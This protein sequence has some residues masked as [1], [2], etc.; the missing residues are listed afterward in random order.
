MELLFS[1]L[2]RLG[3]ITKLM[4]AARKSVYIIRQLP[5]SLVFRQ[6]K[7]ARR[8]LVFPS[9]GLMSTRYLSSGG[10]LAGQE[11]LSCHVVF[12]MGSV[13]TWQGER[14]LALMLT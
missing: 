8:S 5:V 14:T 6:V 9:V 11:N 13:L 12:L 10:E 7:I 1:S 3:I 4:G 2:S